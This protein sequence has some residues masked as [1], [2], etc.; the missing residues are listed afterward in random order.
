MIVNKGKYFICLLSL[1]FL[2]GGCRGKSPA[3]QDTLNSGVIRI[4]VDETLF[5]LLDA[6]L[7]VFEALTPAAGIVPEYTNETRA[8]NLLLADSVRLAIATRP[9]TPEETESFH[10]RKFFPQ[11]IRIATDG[12]ALIVHPGNNDTIVNTDMLRKIFSGEIMQW[13]QLSGGTNKK[14]IRVAFDDPNSSTVRYVLDSLMRGNSLAENCFATGSNAAVVDYVSRTP[15]AIGVIGVNWISDDRDS[16]SM[17]F[18]S[19]VQVMRIG[20]SGSPDVR[21]SFQPYPYYLYTGQYPLRRSVYILLNDP[22][23]G[24]PTGLASFLAGGRGQ[25][26][27]LKNGL[28][29]ATMPVNIVNVT[30]E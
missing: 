29:P 21:N 13:S 2:L 6:E 7:T 9:L 18:L 12:I 19:K 8:I 26:I 27:V 23:S 20:D 16:L 30:D 5:P 24:L 14:N 10:S 3:D 1:S 17:E 15:D 4:A 11:V 28:L 25:R 22:R